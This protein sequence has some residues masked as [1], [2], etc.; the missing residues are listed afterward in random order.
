MTL[1]ELIDKHPEYLDMP[2]QMYDGYKT[3]DGEGFAPYV[4][5]AC[6]HGDDCPA[7]EAG[8]GL[9][10]CPDKYPILTFAGN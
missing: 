2:F 10:S 9:D 5:N 4:A 3:W 6:P 7:I 1:R 8:D